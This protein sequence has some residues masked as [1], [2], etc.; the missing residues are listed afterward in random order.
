MLR[1]NINVTMQLC[2]V[3]EQEPPLSFG[4]L[5]T[6]TL[7][8]RICS[9]VMFDNCADDAEVANMFADN[10]NSVYYDSSADDIAL[11]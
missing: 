1:V 2:T 5:G 4:K 7:K 10:F 3:S 11:Q 9:N 8:K 6:V